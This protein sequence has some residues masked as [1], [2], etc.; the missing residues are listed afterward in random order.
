[1]RLTQAGA[2]T[3]TWS[4]TSNQ[5][6][7]TVTPTSGTGPATLSVAVQFAGAVA[8]SGVR[9]AAIALT[10]VGAGNTDGPIVVRLTTVSAGSAVAPFGFVDTPLDGVA[11]VTGSIAV[12]GWAM[13][14]IE[15]RAVRIMREVAGEGSALI[16]I[17][18]AVFVD[19]A[20][21]DVAGANSTL[22]LN[23][24]AGWGYL[25]L[26]NFLPNQG[27]GTFR[28]V[29]IADD[30]DGHST[31][32]GTKTITCAN[33]SAM[34]PFGAIDTPGQGEIVAGI[35]A[36]FGWVLSRGSTRADPPSGGSVTVFVDGVP[37]GSPGGWV[38]RPDL[39]ALFPVATYSGVGAALGVYTL[40][41]T[42]LANGIHTI[43]W[44]V[45]DNHGGAAGIG[46]R[47]FTV[48]NGS[49][50]TLAIAPSSGR[51]ALRMWPRPLA[52]E[53]E[54]R[55]GFDL[56]A[57]FTAVTANQDGL[58]V[59]NAEELD[60][61]EVRAGAERG[62]L[63]SGGLHALPVGAILQPDGT[64]IWQP[65]VAFIGPYD[66]AFDTPDGERR[67]RII[68]HPAGASRAG[69]LLVID[70]PTAGETVNRSFV[71][72]GW[73]ID[74][75]PR[76]GGVEAIHVWAYPTDGTAPIFLGPVTVA[77]KRPDV[78][79]AYGASFGG[80]GY[81]LAVN[82]L[83]PGGYDL[84]VFAW[85]SMTGTFAPAKTVRVTIR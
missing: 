66:F 56:D 15:V 39:T 70:A 79:A 80:S 33:S 4:A 50:T 77:G 48:L 60:R 42:T 59:V 28:I 44:G 29:A 24:R 10:F 8:T 73:A 41:T 54:V 38:A 32:L 85:N 2:G 18:N 27:N 23:T 31:V 46:S 82:S 83:P 1:V 13:D 16:F 49:A 65:G 22:P 68:L 55:R 6:W 14:D 25:M 67:V 75:N 71:I 11:G 36:N 43:A 17:G 9:N 47:Y 53:I 34:T 58:F 7:L 74:L 37:V 40:N 69:P 52:S 57:P 45:T 3:V 20:R 5:P 84:A 62:R 72:G 76:S 81:G 21:P 12:T 26:T 30:A 51:P 78:A 61:I 64:F 63:R 35:V 19:G